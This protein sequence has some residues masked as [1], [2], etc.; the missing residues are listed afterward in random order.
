MLAVCVTALA[1]AGS[2]LAGYDRVGSSQGGYART[3]STPYTNGFQWYRVLGGPK[4]SWYVFTSGGTLSAS[5]IGG[6]YANGSWS[7]GYNYRYW[8]MY[9]PGPGTQTFDVYWN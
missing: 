1:V 2:A 3:G 9:N 7:G 8:E 6:T 5:G 4:Y